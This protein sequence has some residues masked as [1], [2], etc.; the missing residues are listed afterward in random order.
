MN[1]TSYK[2][3]EAVK[4]LTIKLLE[5]KTREETQLTQVKMSQ[6]SIAAITL[7]P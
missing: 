2:T 1:S 7:S 6:S 5:G 3:K 4:Q